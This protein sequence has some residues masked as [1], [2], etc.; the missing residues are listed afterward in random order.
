VEIG[1]KSQGSKKRNFSGTSIVRRIV[2]GWKENAQGHIPRR[3]PRHL[4]IKRGGVR[5][6]F[7]QEG[8]Q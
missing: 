3:F 4:Y 7:R 8:K 2:R 5:G 6:K 1:K